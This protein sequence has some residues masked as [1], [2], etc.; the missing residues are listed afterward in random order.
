[1]HELHGVE[2]FGLDLSANMVSI[3]WERALKK[4]EETNVHFQIAD[5][6]KSKFEAN[7]FDVIYSRDTILHIDDKQTLFSLF[8][9][10]LKPGGKVFITDYS[11]GPKPWSDDYAQYVAQRGY[12]LLTPQ[13]YGNL[14]VQLGYENVKAIDETPMFI[15][16]LERE[17]V[18]FEKIKTEFEKEFTTEDFDYLVTGWKDKVVRSNSGNQ[19][20]AS[21][22]AEKSNS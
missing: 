9:Y 18:R 4:K 6:M 12:N 19:R 14:F 8:K 13:E 15:E 17:L 5:V 20:W 10:W 11:C 3:A 21:I 16:C 1:M 7:S 2:V 22:Y